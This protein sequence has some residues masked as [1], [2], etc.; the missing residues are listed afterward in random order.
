MKRNSRAP[1]FA[2]ATNRK[3]SFAGGVLVAFGL[4]LAGSIA[5]GA[6]STVL[7]S[8]AALKAVIAALVSA[9]CCTCFPAAASAR[10]A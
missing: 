7:G 4:G 9:T 6:L 2:G 1:A 8:V 3:L 10:D 5:F